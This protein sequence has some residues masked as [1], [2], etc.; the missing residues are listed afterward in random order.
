MKRANFLELFALLLLAAIP[1]GV[2]FLPL[3]LV[4]QT[5]AAL[6]LTGLLPGWLLVGLL[7]GQSEAPPA[8]GE[9]LL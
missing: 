7:V 4:V 2:L 5:S 1:H 6:I 8:F 3:P 9:R